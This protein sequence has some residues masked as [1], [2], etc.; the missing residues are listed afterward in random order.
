MIIH[1]EG[2]D[3]NN[4]FINKY[5]NIQSKNIKELK[6]LKEFKEW[7]CY[8]WFKD[9]CQLDNEYNDWKD[10]DNYEIIFNNQY[11][12]LYIK[13]KN[14]LIITPLISITSTI[15]ELKD[16]LSIKDNIYFK[17]IKLKDNKTLDDYG[18][19]NMETLSVISNIYSSPSLDC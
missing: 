6:R 11:I 5:I 7:A 4:N 19:N 17:Q 10:N 18:I 8:D 1:I 13:I 15:E 9:G 14:K 3:Q 16:I 2:F 12:N